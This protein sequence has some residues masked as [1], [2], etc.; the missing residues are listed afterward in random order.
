MSTQKEARTIIIP[1]ISIAV[2]VHMIRRFDFDPWMHG[3][4]FRGFGF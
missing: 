2:T 1:I 4:G 3:L